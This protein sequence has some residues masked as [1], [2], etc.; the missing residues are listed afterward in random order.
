MPIVS[1]LAALA[2]NKHLDSVLCVDV[3]LWLL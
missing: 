3:G 1:V 2:V